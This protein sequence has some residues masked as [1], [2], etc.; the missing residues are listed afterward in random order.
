M[1]IIQYFQWIIIRH[2]SEKVNEATAWMFIDTSP[3]LAMQQSQHEAS[4]WAYLQKFLIELDEVGWC[5]S[6]D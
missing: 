2:Q 4:K 5:I 1:T 6:G 3:A